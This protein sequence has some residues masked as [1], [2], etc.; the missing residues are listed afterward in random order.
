VTGEVLLVFV[1]AGVF[2]HHF[3]D[4][5]VILV[6]WVFSLSAAVFLCVCAWT[7]P[8][9]LFWQFAVGSAL[10]GV[11]YPLF[12]SSVGSLFSKLIAASNIQGRGQG[13]LSMAMSLATVLGPV[14]SGSVLSIGLRFVLI[15]LAS[16]L[17]LAF[18][19][20]L[21]AFRRLLVPAATLVT[22][23]EANE[24]EPLIMSGSELV[25]KGLMN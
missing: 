15:M 16:C 7:R 10:I 2:A 14:V 21:L 12:E 9:L 11:S 22:V 5:T 13:L 18:G 23:P 25:D 3:H 19:F 20:Y 6:G 1:L 8:A 4:R 24:E 17:L